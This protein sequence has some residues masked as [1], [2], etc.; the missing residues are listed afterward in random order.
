MKIK[1]YQVKSTKLLDYKGSCKI[2]LLTLCKSFFRPHLEYID[3]INDNNYNNAF[4]EK[5]ELIQYK[6]E[7]NITGAIGSNFIKT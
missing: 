7:L 4:Y 2:S 1:V 5:M 3:V 6:A